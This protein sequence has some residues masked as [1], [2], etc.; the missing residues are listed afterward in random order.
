MRG[1]AIECEGI[2]GVWLLSAEDS[3]E[4]AVVMMSVVNARNVGMNKV[5]KHM[6]Q[7]KR[8][9]GGDGES[10]YM[11][12]L[13]FAVHPGCDFWVIRRSGRIEGLKQGSAAEK[14]QRAVDKVETVLAA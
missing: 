8:R 9:S 11:V 14:M 3:A 2:K 7:A 4:G 13:V 1:V 5:L 12:Q 6:L 10:S